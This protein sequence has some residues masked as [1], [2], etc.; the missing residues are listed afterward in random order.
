M[1]S[2]SKLAEQKSKPTEDRYICTTTLDLE[3]INAL[4]RA[5][6]QESDDQ[7]LGIQYKEIGEGNFECIFV[8]NTEHFMGSIDSPLSELIESA[9]AEKPLKS[10]KGRFSY[11]VYL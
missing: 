7:L 9:I 3:A 6:D 1:S 10:L 5:L 4:K 2:E 11:M 8:F